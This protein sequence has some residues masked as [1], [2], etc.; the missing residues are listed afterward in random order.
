MAKEKFI[1]TMDQLRQ[2]V[3]AVYIDENLDY[4]YAMERLRF[5]LNPMYPDNVKSLTYEQC[6]AKYKAHIEIWNSRNAAKEGKGFLGKADSSKRKTFIE[7][8]DARLYKIDWDSV[9]THPVR[10]QYLFGDIRMEF[11]ADQ[12]KNFTDELKFNPD[13]AT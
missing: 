1:P 9:S 3:S 7:F 13:A 8:M 12:V 6:I 2:D 11:L 4:D 5:H 10:D